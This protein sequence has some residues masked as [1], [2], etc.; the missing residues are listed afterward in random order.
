MRTWQL[1]VGLVVL[2]L[3]PGSFLSAQA[4]T[5]YASQMHGTSVKIDGTSTAHDWEMEG[6]VIGGS[7][8][9]GP[10]V[11]LDP[12][13]TGIPGLKE[14]KVPVTVHALIP[15]K[16]IH[17]KAEHAPDIMDHLMQDTMK[18]DQFGRIEYALTEMIF[19]GPHEANTPFA[20]DT[21][22]QLSIAGVTNT[23]SFPVTLEVL[24]DGKIKIKAV[25]PLKMTSYGIKPPAPNIGMGLMRCG[26][27]IKII[28]D[29]TLMAKK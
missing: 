16:L 3:S 10:D 26:D 15:V 27:D 4:Q 18:A 2:L 28:I 9:F 21:T 12:A 8:E 17:S 19:K 1:S 7:A 20:F 14:G 25:T 22:G 11:K 5:R 6:T 13:Q 24:G 23:V 29:W